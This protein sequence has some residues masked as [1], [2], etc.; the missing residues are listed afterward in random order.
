MLSTVW[1]PQSAHN[2]E[3]RFELT[4]IPDSSQLEC[5]GDQDLNYSSIQLG[6]PS[7][8][9]YQFAGPPN[10]RSP[11]TVENTVC[12]NFRFKLLS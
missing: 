4:Q 5:V 11:N 6:I 2:P 10:T 9:G 12:E 8:L 7:N 1:D 3:L